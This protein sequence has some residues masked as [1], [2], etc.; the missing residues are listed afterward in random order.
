MPREDSWRERT[1]AD[2]AVRYSRGAGRLSNLYM[3]QT[4][5][6]G[7]VFLL[8]LFEATDRSADR[9]LYCNLG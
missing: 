1:E 3:K 7:D 2:V 5:G 8:L 6:T 9:V 4:T